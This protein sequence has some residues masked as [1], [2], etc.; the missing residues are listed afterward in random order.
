MSTQSRFKARKKR[1]VVAVYINYSV[2]DHPCRSARRAGNTAAHSAP[3]A[4]ALLPPDSRGAAHCWIA[5]CSPCLGCLQTTLLGLE[6]LLSPAEIET[7]SPGWS[8]ED[9]FTHGACQG[10]RAKSFPEGNPIPGVF[11]TSFPM[12][13]PRSV[14]QY[15]RRWKYLFPERIIVTTQS[16]ELGVRFNLSAMQIPAFLMGFLKPWEEKLLL[17]LF[18][19]F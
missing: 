13:A 10:C 15:P 18:G 1:E 6:R 12:A 16:G 9:R 5:N 8:R 2:L 3:S 4:K 11:P 14:L 17:I 7:T 19:S